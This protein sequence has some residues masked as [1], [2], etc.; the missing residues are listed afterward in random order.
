MGSVWS[1]LLGLRPDMLLSWSGKYTGWPPS[2]R[3]SPPNA[4]LLHER[5]RQSP[6]FTSASESK[7]EKGEGGGDRDGGGGRAEVVRVVARNG[8][9]VAAVSGGGLAPTVAPVPR[10]RG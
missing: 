8:G 6:F 5:E 1:L 2:H 3:P 9:D 4:L 10:Y 7:R